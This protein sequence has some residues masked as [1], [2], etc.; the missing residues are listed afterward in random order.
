[1]VKLFTLIEFKLLRRFSSKTCYVCQI[2]LKK[3]SIVN[4][5]DREREDPDQRMIK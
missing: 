3:L 2:K 5:H 4:N 1:M